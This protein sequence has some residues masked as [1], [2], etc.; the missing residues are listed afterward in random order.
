MF[1][2]DKHR[3]TYHTQCYIK[4]Q[5]NA[6][7]KSGGWWKAGQHKRTPP[8]FPPHITLC[9]TASKTCSILLLIRGFILFHF[10]YSM[11]YSILCS[12]S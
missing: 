11:N 3:H 2:S 7:A 12:H 10:K 8:Q 4:A 6:A 1:L 5:N 9:S